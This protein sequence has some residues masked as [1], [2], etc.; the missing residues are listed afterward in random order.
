MKSDSDSNIL[1]GASGL[2]TD[3]YELTMAQGYFLQGMQEVPATF[4]YFFRKFP[5]D[6]GYVIFSGLGEILQYLESFRFN[7]ASLSY[8]EKQGF[9]RSF[10]GWL[11]DFRFRG[12]LYAVPEGEVVFPYEP[13]IRVEGRMPEVQLVETLLLNTVN[14]SSLTATKAARMR[15]EAG[16]RTL[17][18]FGLRRAQGLGGIMASKAS[19]H[20]GFDSTSNEYSAFRFGLEATGTMAHSWIQAFGS[21]LEA[22]RAFARFFPDRCILLVDTYDTLQSGIPNAI[23]VAHELVEKGHQ[24]V[25]IRLDSGDLAYLSKRAREMLDSEGL[26][27]VKIVASNQLDEH[28]IHSLINQ[29]APVDVFGIGTAISTGKDAGALDGVY[30]LTEIDGSPTLKRSENIQKITLPGKKEIYRFSD[31]EGIFRADG[32]QLTGESGT[33]K[34]YHPFETEKSTRV[35]RL[36]GEKLTRLVMEDGEIK[37]SPGHPHEIRDYVRE[38]LLQLPEEHKR[39]L[40]PHPY[41]V[42]ISEKLLRLREQLLES[43][44]EHKIQ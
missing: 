5:F 24:L 4:D 11:K 40:N 23:R 12:D 7:E 19:V 43:E 44:Y 37:Q 13:C 18:E 31:K 32:I 3:R 38:R 34:I 21:E 16:D 1:G 30:K 39:I 29:D 20:G 27:E 36:R 26:S 28:V 2:Y 9:D 42:G 8:L 6:G 25:G 10:V 41:K 14:F 33:K 17:M 35:D 22:F 15:Q